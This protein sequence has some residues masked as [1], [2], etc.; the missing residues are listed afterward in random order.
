MARKL[1]LLLFILGLVC[2][3]VSIVSGE[4][5]VGIF[6]IFPFVAGT[7]WLILVGVL[8]VFTGVFLYLVSVPLLVPLSDKVGKRYRKKTMTSRAGGMVL[9]GPI[10]IVVSSDAR[11]AVLLLVVGISLAISIYL[12]IPLLF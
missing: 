10:P 1:S 9:I 4:G 6:I 11:L 2:I 8:L 12:F 5:Q 7:G 3:I